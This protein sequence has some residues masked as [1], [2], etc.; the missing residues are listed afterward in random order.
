LVSLAIGLLFSVIAPTQQLAILLAM[1]ATLLPTILL[2]GFVFQVSNLPLPIR[3]VSYL[4]PATHFLVVIRGI[5]LK[6][7][8]MAV[9]WKQVAVLSGYAVLLMAI[10][11][12][13]FRKRIS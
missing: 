5:Y 2:S 1:L 12:K 10:A 7:V 4:L 3:M 9:L 13:R 8:G 6:G 11:A